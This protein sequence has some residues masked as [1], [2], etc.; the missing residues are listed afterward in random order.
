MCAWNKQLHRVDALLATKPIKTVPL[1]VVKKKMKKKIRVLK[2]EKLFTGSSRIQFTKEAFR[3]NNLQVFFS[4]YIQHK[5]KVFE[6]RFVKMT[7]LQINL[8]TMLQFIQKFYEEN[9]KF[10]LNS[11]CALT[12]T[13]DSM[14]I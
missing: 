10:C 4:E 11:W 9:A 3:E 6:R 12:H 7:N 1:S 14:Y 2:L 8:C 5:D 13:H